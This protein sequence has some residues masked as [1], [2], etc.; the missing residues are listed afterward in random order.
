MKKTIAIK[1]CP[2]CNSHIFYMDEIHHELYCNSCGLIIKAPPSMDFIT[3]G[4]KTIYIT[5][6]LP[7]TVEIK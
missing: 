6:N 7:E 1:V 4:F 3:T 5:L 2:E